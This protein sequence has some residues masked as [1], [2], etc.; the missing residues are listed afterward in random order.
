MQL[1]RVREVVKITGLSRMTIYRLEK[2]GEFPSRRRLGKNSIA[3]IDHEVST[4]IAQRPPMISR[5]SKPDNA[6]PRATV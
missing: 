6:P 5:I 2:E 3:W 4:W 1:L